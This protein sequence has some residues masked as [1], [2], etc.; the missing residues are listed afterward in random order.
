M[1]KLHILKIISCCLLI[2]IIGSISASSSEPL[3]ESD[4]PYANNF[5]RTWTVNKSGADQIRLH[6]E[7]I[8][9]GSY[10]D[11]DLLDKYDNV[12]RTYNWPT[13]ELNLWTDWYTGDTLK[14]RLV[15]DNSGTSYGFKIDDVDTRSS[16]YK[17]NDS[18][19]ESNH[20][21]ANNFEKIWTINKSGA[22]QIRLHFENIE[23]ASYDDLYLLDK[24]DNVLNIYNWPTKERNLWTDWYTG[25]TLKIRLVT[26]G[27]GIDYGFKTDKLE[28]RLNGTNRSSENI[29]TSKSTGS[30]VQSNYA[31]TGG[32]KIL[33]AT[34]ITSSDNPLASGQ[35][36]TL[37]SK[38]D[39]PSHEEEP[40]G[41]VT[42]MDGTTSVGTEDVISGQATLHISSLSAGSHSITAKYSGDNNCKSSIS[43]ALTLTVQ[44]QSDPE[45]SIPDTNTDGTF[46]ANNS[47]I[48]QKQPSTLT[49]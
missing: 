8:E 1:S 22:D 18:L 10:D 12:L 36:V 40:L 16:I 14:V 13:A 25:D 26:D 30:E 17:S 3:P 15:T 6:F 35:S 47:T 41:T 33:T 4:H 48:V 37:I 34:E 39:T 46:S 9:I 43:P 42:F 49:I 29:G 28:T 5:E 44:E 24:Y 19:A 20:P 27:S 32:T 31:K 21:Y 23:I 45:S 38:V 11:L 2:I 7:N